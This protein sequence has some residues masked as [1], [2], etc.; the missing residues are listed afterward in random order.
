MNGS[1]LIGL[2]SKHGVNAQFNRAFRRI[3]Y[4][5]AQSSKAVS[6]CFNLRHT[7]SCAEI[8]LC[9][10]CVWKFNGAHGHGEGVCSTLD[11]SPEKRLKHKIFICAPR[12]SA[13]ASLSLEAKKLVPCL[14]GCW[15]KGKEKKLEMCWLC[16]T[17]EA[18][19]LETKKEDHSFID[20]RSD[21]Q[22]W[23]V[24]SPLEIVK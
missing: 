1:L 23:S 2:K 22:R 15:L 10:V 17:P 13:W 9:C 24:P 19:F 20:G 5:T 18:F 16:R 11:K 8:R 21:T 4:Q 3:R 14:T 12:K 7:R 6:V